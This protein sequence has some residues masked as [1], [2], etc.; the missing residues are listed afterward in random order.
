MTGRP[1]AENET[2]KRTNYSSFPRVTAGFAVIH[3]LAFIFA[4]GATAVG[5]IVQR[6]L[7]QR[8]ATGVVAAVLW[9][10]SLLLLGAM[11][12]FK[13]VEIIP[14]SKN[15]EMQRWNKERR[16]SV[17]RRAS[18]VAEAKAVGRKDLSSIPEEDVGWKPLILGNPTSA[19]R[20]INVIELGS[21]TRW[22]EIRKRNRL[23]DEGGHGHLNRRAMGF[24]REE[25]ERRGNELY[26]DIHRGGER[27]GHVAHKVSRRSLRS[28][29]SYESNPRTP[30]VEL[31]DL[32]SHSPA[33]VGRAHR[34]APIPGGSA[35]EE[36]GDGSFIEDTSV[37]GMDSGD[38]DF[39]ADHVGPMD[40]S[41][42]G[43]EERDFEDVNLENGTAPPRSK[44]QNKQD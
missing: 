18:V 17:D 12:R 11:V 15:G 4:A 16:E 30:A 34:R 2:Q 23:I 37:H 14:R 9:G 41:K 43:I 25:L 38:I 22:T 42:A 20:R 26:D 13:K 10:L 27:I 3:T 33:G 19:Y 7:G 24:A 39:E 28:K 32:S 40:E 6:K 35:P 21:L 31:Q 8:T 36:V 5:G 1:R 29:R 44:S